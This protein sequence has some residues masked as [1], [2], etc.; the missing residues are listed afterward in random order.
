[1]NTMDWEPYR[2]MLGKVNFDI[3]NLPPVDD[4]NMHNHAGRNFNIRRIRETLYTLPE[5]LTNKN[6]VLESIIIPRGVKVLPANTFADITI[7]QL[8]LPD[9]LMKIGEKCFYHTRFNIN[10]LT[11]P[12]SLREVGKQA[13]ECST[14]CDLEFGNRLL[15][16]R[17]RLFRG[18]NYRRL[19]F[20]GAHIIEDS[21]FKELNEYDIRRCFVEVDKAMYLGDYAFSES[22][23]TIIYCLQKIEYMG[24]SCFY[25]SNFY[26]DISD[27]NIRRLCVCTYM[28][29][30]VVSVTIPRNVVELGDCCF[31]NC[32]VLNNVILPNGLESIGAFCFFRCFSLKE[33]D[34]PKTVNVI[35]DYGFFYCRS[36]KKM[37]HGGKRINF[38]TEEAEDDGAA[39]MTVDI[40]YEYDYRTKKTFPDLYGGENT[41]NFTDLVNEYRHVALI[42]DLPHGFFYDNFDAEG[43][44]NYDFLGNEIDLDNY[45]DEFKEVEPLGTAN[46]LHQI[47]FYCP[48]S[49]LNSYDDEELKDDTECNEPYKPESEGYIKILADPNDP[50]DA[51][52]YFTFDRNGKTELS[53]DMNSLDYIEI[54][55]RASSPV[56][57]NRFGPMNWNRED[58]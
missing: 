52:E 5:N 56:T 13:F 38:E 28:N 54:I 18:A 27:S 36:L 24:R 34:I 29:S 9:S 50:D 37:S 17:R 46:L 26:S 32:Y 8:V 40:K 31:A 39:Y 21:C 57:A 49:S 35:G 7:A 25:K 47:D 11:F 42:N 53:H 15:V 3:D 58:Q 20:G 22:K 30:N 19:S 10:L 2:D 1:M 43:N 33:I 51:D 45:E 16:L 6:L 41:F 14:G 55:D 48:P 12:K 4:H 44:T 23:I